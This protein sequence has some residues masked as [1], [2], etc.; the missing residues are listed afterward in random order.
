V[1]YQD[2][3]IRLDAEF[4]ASTLTGTSA[5]TGDFQVFSLLL[6]YET[7]DLILL[8]HGNRQAYR[9]TLPPE[10]YDLIQPQDPMTVLTSKEFIDAFNQEGVKYLG[11][12]RLKRRDFAG[13]KAT[14]IEMSFRVMIPKADLAEMREAGIEF[15]PKFTLRLY[16]EQ[17]TNFPLL[18]EMDSSM[19]QVTF[20]LVNLQRDRLPD[21][22]FEIPAFYT[23]EEFTVYDL[24]SLVSTIT[25]DLGVKGEFS[26]PDE[27]LEEL[28]PEEAA[29][30]APEPEGD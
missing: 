16:L 22:L 11:T 5:D 21:V 17:D 26:V 24:E 6:G 10:L 30:I 23:V 13:L 20:Q 8:V 27:V 2:G 12:K 9:L 19:F 18:Y 29:L 14:G 28:T 1:Y 7:Y 15:D 25:R 4:P 3:I